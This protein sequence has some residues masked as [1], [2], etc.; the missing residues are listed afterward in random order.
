VEQRLSNKTR[1]LIGSLGVLLV[2]AVA[3]FFFLRY[4]IRKSFPETSG[5][6]T[7]GGLH[8]PV[9]IY[10]DEYGVPRLEAQDEH[11]LMFAF[12]YVHAQDRLWQMD[13]ARRV[14]E[15]RLSEL[16]GSATLEFDKMFRTIGIRRICEDIERSLPDESRSR[17]Q[18]YADG[19][20]AFI[21]THVGKYPVEF[22]LLRYTPESWLPRHTL[23]MGRLMS[24]QL[25]LSW[26]TDLTYGALIERLGLDK[27]TEILP[28]YPAGAPLIVPGA[29]VQKHAGLA[30]PFLQTSRAF[31]AFLGQLNMSGGSNAWVVGPRK[32]VTGKVLL[33]NDTHLHLQ[34][35]SQWY[36]V[37]LH[38]P[39][40]HVTGFSIP[41]APV[42]VIGSNDSIAWGLTNAMVDDADF[43]IE[44][45]DEAD[46]TR[47]YYDGEWHPMLFR[48]EE[49]KVKG[50]TLVPLVI[51]STHHGPIVSDIR[52]RLQHSGVPFVASMRWTG[53]E[54]RDQLSAFNTI[55]RAR[56]WKEFTDGV[57]EFSGPGQ[58][59][60]YGDAAGN[61]GYWCG[62]LVPIRENVRSIIPLPGWE[63]ATE[64][65]G[66]VPF[67]RL[68]HMYNPPAGFIATANNKIVD[69]S[70]PYYI[71]DLWEPP[72]R[73]Q[74]LREVLSREDRFS[75]EDFMR[76]QNDKFSAY[77]KEITPF[78]FNAFPDSITD[79]PEQDAV[80]EFLRNWHFT[81]N[82]EDIA[83]SIFHAFFTVLVENIFKDEMGDE[84]FHDWVLLVNVPHRVT[85]KMLQDG[86]SSWFDDVR[87]EE[88]ETR[89]AI[90][91]K[92]MKKAI[93]VLGERFG[94]D[95]K[96]WRWG[97]L[98]TVTLPHF[99]G[100]QK[101]LDKI[102]NIGPFPY[103]GGPFVLM[104]GEYSHN[105]P[106]RVTVG[107]SLRHIVD[108]SRPG[109]MRTVLTSGQSG[110]VFN[111]HYSDQTS[112]WLHGSYRTMV[113]ERT[114]ERSAQWQHL[115]L[116]PVK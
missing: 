47:Y 111:R 35:P 43:Y 114:P 69:D 5:T 16:F 70:Y 51:R 74:R 97:D 102:F 17:I 44:R 99:F 115:R 10:R 62:A 85:M 75:I 40:Y 60:V 58:N 64:W 42:V 104:S 86:T 83:T 109:E 93:G 26:W 89:D 27:V 1:I 24:W 113:T 76:L 77:A 4:Q 49:I 116:E 34:N 61:I 73:S 36:E 57:R 78:I 92:S 25:N 23:M 103:G 6:L 105:E 30:T 68:P 80:F 55:N 100:L 88:I 96:T 84:L 46:T 53:C 101:P 41:G 59:F 12:G 98:H 79:F 22:D 32:S 39:G 95:M 3:G 13:L 2:A 28:S 91:R 14:G 94:P 112:L 20:N 65:K 82:E 56:N 48:E 29:D 67:E 11:D 33:A 31:A 72:S 8:Q 52:T 71:S 18:S 38:A 90:I 45:L 7:I 110:Q 66:F 19:I 15:G 106:F 54:I 50:D 108:F 107:A 63:K 37:H 87:T 9:D 81:F 21:V